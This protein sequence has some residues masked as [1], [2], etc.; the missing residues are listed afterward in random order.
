MNENSDNEINKTGK[1][2]LIVVSVFVLLFAIY[3]AGLSI[4]APRSK[5][6][7]INSE[8]GYKKPEKGGLNDSIF[9]DSAF[10]VLNRQKA[11][12][13]ARI[14]MASSDS[15]ALSVNLPDST[16][17]LEINGVTVYTTKIL[18]SRMSKVF[19]KAD[20]YAV[21]MLFSK[22]FTIIKD[23][24]S[25]PKE[26]VIFKV[27]PKDTTEYKP[28]AP[29]DTSK[30]EYVNF[31]LETREGIRL[32]VYQSTQGDFLASFHQFLFDLYDRIRTSASIVKCMFKFKKPE[33]KP[34]IKIRVPIKDARLIYRALPR[35]GQFAVSR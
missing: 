19:R 35:N 5:I 21:T 30:I 1:I 9:M 14:A 26:P 17:S 18:S 33:Y 23:Y 24:S 3:Y 20:E 15:V 13:Q 11:F 6:N 27:A 22:P 32:Y 34:W 4:S 16:A 10:V 29:P 8:Y 7:S 31:I 25:I 2:P 28:D 12:Y